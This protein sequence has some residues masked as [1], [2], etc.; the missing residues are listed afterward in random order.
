MLR[1]EERKGVLKRWFWMIILAT[2]ELYGGTLLLDL[3]SC[4]S[5]LGSADL[6]RMVRRH[7]GPV[8]RVRPVSVMWTLR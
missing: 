7:V 1:R 5:V 3:P 2:A 6:S 4:T 8:R